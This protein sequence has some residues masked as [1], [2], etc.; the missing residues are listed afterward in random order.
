MKL[1]SGKKKGQQEMTEYLV[2]SVVMLFTILLIV[3]F[4]FGWSFGEAEKKQKK[5]SFDKAL[6]TVNSFLHSECFTK[7]GKPAL[8]DDSKL[9]V[10]TGEDGCADLAKVIGVHA[11]VN[12][13]RV[14]FTGEAAA[15]CTAA[16]YPECSS[17][18]LCE[19]VCKNRGLIG[20]DIPVNVYRKFGNVVEL[21]M[22]DVRIAG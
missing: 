22:L 5:E 8:L 2:M 18:V 6:F 4:I 10:Y 21:A 1:I 16:T 3:F 7:D 17:W 13:S 19:S 11:C 9:L 12:V 14:S 15:K 20:F